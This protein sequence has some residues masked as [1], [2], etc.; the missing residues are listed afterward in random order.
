[1]QNFPRPSDKPEMSALDLDAL[2]TR[3]RAEVEARKQQ[4]AADASIVAAPRKYDADGLLALPAAAFIRESYSTIFG[5]APDEQE[6]ATL[7]DRLLTGN[8]TRSGVLKELLDTDE[9]KAR[10]ARIDGLFGSVARDNFRRSAPGRWLAQIGHALRTIYL[11]PKRIGQFLKRVDAIERTASETA[12]KVD[13]L[14]QKLA[15]LKDAMDRREPK[16]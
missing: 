5:R 9:A 3:V 2:M 15:A 6:F 10:N 4:A 11:L 12:L 1:M 13:A 7:R 14:D 16:A 8:V